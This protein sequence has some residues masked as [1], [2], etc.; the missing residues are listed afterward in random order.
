MNNP[1]I[2]WIDLWGTMGVCIYKDDKFHTMTINKVSIENMI[3]LLSTHLN[4]YWIASLSDIDMLV[5]ALPNLFNKVFYNVMVNQ[6]KQLWVL[7][8]II[9]RHKLKVVKESH[10]NKVVFEKWKISK[11]DTVLFIKQK[12]WIDNLITEHEADAAKFVLFYL[13]YIDELYTKPPA[14]STKH[15]RWERKARDNK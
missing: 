2:V 14:K 10:A 11:T 8:N 6:A 12:L 4:E 7:E 15:P 9:T 1:L 5:T 3:K 13:K